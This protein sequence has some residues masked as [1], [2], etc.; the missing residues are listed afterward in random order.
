[1]RITITCLLGL[2]SL[3]HADEF[4]R[5]T[6]RVPSPPAILW[7]K[8]AFADGQFI[9]VG[10]LGSIMTSTNGREWFLE[11]TVTTN[12][13]LNV[14]YGDRYV[15]SGNRGTV[16]ASPDAHEWR[17]ASFPNDHTLLAM[18]YGNDVYAAFDVYGNFYHSTNALNWE[19]VDPPAPTTGA[20]MAFGGDQFVMVG[21]AG[22]IMTST[23]GLDWVQRQSNTTGDFLSVAFGAGK[24]VAVGSEIDGDGNANS[25]IETSFNGI[26]WFFQSLNTDVLVKDLTYADGRFVIVGGDGYSG[27]SISLNSSDGIYYNSAAGDNGFGGSDVNG[28]ACG[29]GVCVA[30]GQG[31]FNSTDGGLTWTNINSGPLATIYDFAQKDGTV[32]GVGDD[33]VIL[34]TID[35]RA[36]VNQVVGSSAGWR[37]LSVGSG[38]FVAAG[39]D[40]ALASSP[41]GLGWTSYANVTAGNIWSVAY[42]AGRFVAVAW[43]AT[44]TPYGFFVTSTNGTDW[45]VI[46]PLGNVGINASIAFGAGAFVVFANNG[47]YYY[48]QDGLTWTARNTGYGHY[49]LPVFYCNNEF[50]GVEPSVGVLTSSDGLS[51]VQHETDISG[52]RH[53]SHGNGIYLAVGDLPGSGKMWSSADGL[54]W[55]TEK[56]G[57]TDL[58]SSIYAYDS[59]YVGGTVLQSETS[60]IPSLEQVTQGNGQLN[61]TV[62]GRIG[63]DYELQSS[64][65]LKTWQHE[66]DY[67]QGQRIQPLA[68]PT[69]PSQK[70]YRVKLKEP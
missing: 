59:F 64:T 34:T 3:C 2:M 42:G 5:W 46:K 53:V 7:E 52:V 12:R 55:K 57:V 50:L 62:F 43:E 70:F 45:E 25:F 26:D 58:R 22:L 31:V 10:D 23:N 66:S 27:G 36:W 11:N 9:A 35:G 54:N 39:L 13:L 56:I 40:G 69:G 18:A 15:A 41:D 29:N 14:F 63:R 67:N 51:W 47:Y 30:V 60:L 68:L 32:V 17:L 21:A 6:W 44:G 37:S 16:V 4:S 28:V 49:V 1:M 65:D 38:V 48:S 61:A 8:V 20:D 33:G 24:F 19:T